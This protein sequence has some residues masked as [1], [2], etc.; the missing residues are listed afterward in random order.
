MPRKPEVLR[1]IPLFSL[2]DEEEAAV[3]AGV[4]VDQPTSGEFCGFASM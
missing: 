1:G 3:L 2:L 4:V